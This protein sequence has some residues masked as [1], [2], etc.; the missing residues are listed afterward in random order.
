[1]YNLFDLF[2]TESRYGYS[3]K[4]LRDRSYSRERRDRRDR[5]VHLKNAKLKEI[6]V[7][8]MLA[9]KPQQRAAKTA[10]G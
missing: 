6:L 7:L 8:K 2:S 10:R 5:F 4:D 9:Q 1:M 3:R